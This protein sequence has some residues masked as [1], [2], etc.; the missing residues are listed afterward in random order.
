MVGSYGTCACGEYGLGGCSGF[1]DI[2]LR[3]PASGIV[4]S[5][6]GLGVRGSGMGF[7]S[8]CTSEGL[9][10]RVLGLGR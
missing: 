7:W 10:E 4:R 5:G 9:G 1:Q 2:A 3:A 8:G 6:L